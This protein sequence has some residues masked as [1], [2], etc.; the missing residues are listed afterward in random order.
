MDWCILL[1]HIYLGALTPS[2]ILAS[3]KFFVGL[4]LPRAGEGGN[5]GE[6]KRCIKI[7]DAG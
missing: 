6:G 7:I 4:I 2:E 1:G 5:W 3:A